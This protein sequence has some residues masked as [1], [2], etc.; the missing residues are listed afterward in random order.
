MIGSYLNLVSDSR[1]AGIEHGKKSC[2]LATWD[3]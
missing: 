3:D 2:G 1:R